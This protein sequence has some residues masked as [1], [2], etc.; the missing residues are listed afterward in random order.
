MKESEGCRNMF[1]LKIKVSIALEA[2]NA[3]NGLIEHGHFPE[4][5][6]RVLCLHRDIYREIDK[7]IALPEDFHIDHFKDNPVLY[8]VKENADKSD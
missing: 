8:K 7:L 4:L 3:I 6:N 2:L 5:K 1:E